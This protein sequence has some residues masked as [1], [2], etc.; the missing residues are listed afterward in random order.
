MNSKHSPEHP[1]QAIERLGYTDCEARFL[2]LVAT[3]SGYFLPRQFLTFAQVGRGNRSYRFVRKLASRGHATW[4]QYH[5]IGGVYHLFSKTIYREIDRENLR[6]R[7]RH[8]TEFI[9]TRL[10]LL[11]FIL[12][13]P[14]H[15]YLETEQAKLNYFCEEIHVPRKALPARSYEGA[16]D[17]EPVVRYFVD[18][19]PLYLDSTAARAA[20]LLTL[21]YVDPGRA[22]LAGLRTHLRVYTPLF[23]HLGDFRFLYISDSTVHFPKAEECFHSMVAVPL[24]RGRSE[25]LARYFRLRAAWDA[26]HYGTFSGDDIE[27][28]NQA[29]LRFE[30]PK[31][32]EL[33][34]LSTKGE[35]TEE[36]FQN[37]IEQAHL[38]RTIQFA[39]CLVGKSSSSGHKTTEEE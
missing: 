38:G 10:L 34:S 28:L 6:N 17:S 15:D 2:Y 30:G 31:I 13:N 19:F 16:N 9:R 11:D 24:D 37:V 32:E 25:E 21:S 39:R 26:K 23:R 22:S 8:A 7:R 20:P 33:Y 3:H 4:R 5:G 29:H 27:W 35:L 12:Q 36:G 18:G 1:S 14:S